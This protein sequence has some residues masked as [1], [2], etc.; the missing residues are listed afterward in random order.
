MVSLPAHDRRGTMDQGEDRAHG[1]SRPF[2]AELAERLAEIEDRLRAMESME[3]MARS[4]RALTDRIVPPEARRHF[5]SGGRES[6]L[7]MRS[8]VDAWIRRLDLKE[9]EAESRSSGREHIDIE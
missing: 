2:E 3:S 1:G 7:G 5:R 6:L 4:G 8:I 9:E